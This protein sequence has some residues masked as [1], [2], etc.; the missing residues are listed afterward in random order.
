MDAP[1]VKT[2][3]VSKSERLEQVGKSTMILVAENQKQSSPYAPQCQ[4]ITMIPRINAEPCANF[5]FSA[6]PDV[7]RSKRN[8]C[9]EMTACA[10]VP[11]HM[12]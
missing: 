3:Y 9:R 2:G 10:V 11:I 8:E 6:M 7:N 1:I 5:L 4:K 12:F